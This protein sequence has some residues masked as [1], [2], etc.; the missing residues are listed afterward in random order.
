MG[1]HLN[2]NMIHFWDFQ[3]SFSCAKRVEFKKMCKTEKIQID[4]QPEKCAIF[5]KK[6]KKMCRIYTFQ[7]PIIFFPPNWVVGK[8]FGKNILVIDFSIQVQRH[9][10]FVIH[11]WMNQVQGKYERVWL[12]GTTKHAQTSSLTATS[13]HETSSSPK[14]TKSP[15]MWNRGCVHGWKFHTTSH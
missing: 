2:Y 14:H 11:W 1:N 3:I 15:S 13:W 7:C 9:G 8:R 5:F 4:V 6:F 10:D 12:R